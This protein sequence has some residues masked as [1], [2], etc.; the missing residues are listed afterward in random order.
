MYPGQE[1]K[2][3]QELTV[4]VGQISELEIPMVYSLKFVRK[5]SYIYKYLRL[6]KVPLFPLYWEPR[7][8]FLLTLAFS[9]NNLKTKT[10]GLKLLLSNT[11]AG[12]FK[13]ALQE[14]EEYS[15]QRRKPFYVQSVPYPS[16]ILFYPSVSYSLTHLIESNSFK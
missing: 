2:H 13:I 7:I 5:K 11:K 6:A 12:F 9:S 15:W 16:C 3:K 4:Q 8:I 10:S 1:G 14:K